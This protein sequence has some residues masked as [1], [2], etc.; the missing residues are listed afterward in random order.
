MKLLIVGA[1]GHGRVVAEA[2]SRSQQIESVAFLDDR[3]PELKSAF[4][5]PVVGR[6]AD[7][8]SQVA[9][10]DSCIAAFGDSRLRLDV[11]AA[12]ESLG[13]GLPAIVH[14]KATIARCVRVAEGTVVFAGA[15]VNIGA[16]IGRGVIVNSGAVV[17]HDCELEEGVHICPAA[18]LAGGVTVGRCSWIGIGASVVEQV[19]I[20]AEVTVGAGAVC[21]RDVRDRQTVAGVP[22]REIHE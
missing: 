15:I 19:R 1:G 8:P 17:E 7:L 6:L 18:S 2:A 13:F 16:V 9:S 12:A 14:P 4:D 5:W 22:A 20:G 10:F 21:L 11:L 3:F